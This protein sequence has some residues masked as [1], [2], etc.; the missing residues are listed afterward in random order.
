MDKTTLSGF[1]SGIFDPRQPDESKYKRDPQRDY[2][3]FMKS[4]PKKEDLKSTRDHEVDPGFIAESLDDAKEATE[5]L[6]KSL[7]SICTTFAIVEEKN[8]VKKVDSILKLFEKDDF[9]LNE[10]KTSL[11][12]LLQIQAE[13]K[14]SLDVHGGG[15][16]VQV[17]NV[18]SAAAAFTRMLEIF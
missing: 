10:V 17:G 3:F 2:D 18:R 11:I 6:K 7:V 8:L 15:Q 16:G 1:E 12:E 4:I 14:L 13:L 5:I 9:G